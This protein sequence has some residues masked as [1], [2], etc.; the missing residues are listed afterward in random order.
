MRFQKLH[1]ALIADLRG[2][3][4]RN[5]VTEV[6]AQLSLAEGL[7]RAL[8]H[9]IDDSSSLEKAFIDPEAGSVVFSGKNGASVE[10]ELEKFLLLFS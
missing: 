1:S 5:S 8:N 10:L 3:V 4:V 6:A 7:V 2:E 9:R